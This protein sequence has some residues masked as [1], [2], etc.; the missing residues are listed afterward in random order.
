MLVTLLGITT[1]CKDVKPTNATALMSV[2]VE[3]IFRVTTLV[4]RLTI[5]CGIIVV[6]LAKVT[7]V[8]VGMCPN[9][10]SSSLAPVDRAYIEAGKVTDVRRVP[11]NALI[12][13]TLSPSGR[14]MLSR[15]VSRKA[16][17]P[18]T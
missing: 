13:M 17:C 16:L 4:E 15:L 3:G 18:I 14:F 11:L 2:T 10:E 5:P 9:G 1:L 8:K 12:P 6:P 7:V